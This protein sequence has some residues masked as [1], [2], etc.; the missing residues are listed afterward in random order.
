MAAEYVYLGA[1]GLKVSRFALGTMTMGGTA[2]SQCDEPTS[3]AILDAY[4]A[5]K[6]AES[7]DGLPAIDR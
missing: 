1:T 3:F 2:A 5:A 6:N 7:I 4:V